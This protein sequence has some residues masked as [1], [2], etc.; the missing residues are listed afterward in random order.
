MELLDSKEP[1]GFVPLSGS[2]I[3]YP[4]KSTIGHEAAYLI[5][6]FWK[7]YYPTEL[8][9]PQYKPDVE[10]IKH[11]YLMWSHLKKLAEGGPD[12]LKKEEPRVVRDIRNKLP[13]GW[14]CTVHRDDDI[15]L[16]PL[17]LGKPFF[18]VVASNRN[19]SFVRDPDA[20]RGPKMQSPVIPLYF[21]RQT[22]KAEI[23]KIIEKEGNLSSN[24][25]VF[26]GETDEFVVVTSPAFVNDG[27]FTPEARRALRP[28]W[29][30]LRD[31]IPKK[32]N[33]LIDVDDLAADNP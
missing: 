11:W 5:E 33:T 13:A 31:L 9:S 7:R 16:V 24:I 21:Y 32:E 29:K 6:G 14:N 15:T 20:P 17:G 27:L 8:T 18:Q 30:V 4:G 2:S 23:M 12:D 3:H 25:P 28:M 1:C 26:F 22:E 19:V 10:G